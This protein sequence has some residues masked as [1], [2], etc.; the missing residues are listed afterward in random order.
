MRTQIYHK[1]SIKGRIKDILTVIAQLNFAGTHSHYKPLKC[2]IM[3]ANRQSNSLSLLSLVV[4]K[5]TW[6]VASNLR[7]NTYSLFS[8]FF[9]G[10]FTYLYIVSIL[11]LLYV[12]CFLLHE[13][14]CCSGPPSQPTVRN[15]Y[16]HVSN[17]SS[18]YFGS[19]FL[20]S[21]FSLVVLAAIRCPCFSWTW[22]TFG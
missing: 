7:H 19:V 5:H 4:L 13:Y 12:F 9:Q 16:F 2:R 1:A 6:I 18:W 14:S 22:G 20:F 17:P 15:A 8:G 3:P 10:L 21:T 11:F